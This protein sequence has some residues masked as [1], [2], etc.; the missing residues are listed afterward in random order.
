M[1]E[2]TPLKRQEP[3]PS[4][5]CSMQFPTYILSLILSRLLIVKQ[6]VKVAE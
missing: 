1:A 5:D 6:I 4:K 3:N 2:V